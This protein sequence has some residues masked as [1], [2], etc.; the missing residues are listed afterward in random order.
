MGRLCSPWPYGSSAGGRKESKMKKFW[1]YILV[2]FGLGW[3]L[4]GLSILSLSWEPS[5]LLYTALLALCMFAPLAGTWLASGGLKREISGVAWT[6]GISGKTIGWWLA[7][8]FGPAVVAVLGAALYF[9]LFPSRFDGALSALNAQLLAQGYSVSPWVIAG[10]SLVQAITYAPFINMFFALGE[11]VGWRGWMTPFLC[12]RV[13]RK[14]GLILS[15][16]IWGAWHWPVILLVGYNFGSGYWG[17]PFTGALVMCLSC[18]ALGI[19]LSLLYEKTESVWSPAL[20]HGAFNAAAGMGSVCLTP[21]TTALIL[22]PTPLGLIAG[23]PLYLLAAGLL[24]W[25]RKK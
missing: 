7:A 23:I 21:G 20:A 15:G 1:I 19:L 25:P 6:L 11:E 10:V 5:G 9:L 17:A 24:L 8:W 4:Q 16:V 13:G 2:T 12:Q 22:G 18:A 3:L 14:K